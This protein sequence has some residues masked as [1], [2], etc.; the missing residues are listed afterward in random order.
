MTLA[1][2]GM[3]INHEVLRK[4]YNDLAESVQA[5]VDGQRLLALKAQMG[6]PEPHAEPR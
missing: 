2:H 6:W 5:I 3:Q 4:K 1:Q